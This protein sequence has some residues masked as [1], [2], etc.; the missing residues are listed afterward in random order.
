MART[1]T[2][3]LGNEKSRLANIVLAYSETE[4]SFIA[5]GGVNASGQSNAQVNLSYTA[6]GGIL[7]S[8]DSTDSEGNRQIASGGVVVSGESDINLILSF[9]GSGIITASG[10][11]AWIVNPVVRVATGGV[12]LSGS[13]L[14]VFE[15]RSC[16]L[17]ISGVNGPGEA[18]P[19]GVPV[20]EEFRVF[21][22]C[23]SQSSVGGSSVK[24]FVECIEMRYINS[25]FLSARTFCNQGLFVLNDPVGRQIR[26]LE[27]KSEDATPLSFFGSRRHYKPVAPIEEKIIEQEV[28]DSIVIEDPILKNIKNTKKRASKNNN[29]LNQNK[30]EKE[31]ICFDSIIEKSLEILGVNYSYVGFSK[32][33]DNSENLVIE[34]VILNEPISK[35]ISNSKKRARR[36]NTLLETNK[37]NKPIEIENELDFYESNDNLSSLALV[38]KE[39]QK[40]KSPK[41][42]VESP[43]PILNHGKSIKKN[44]HRRSSAPRRHPKLHANKKEIE[45]LQEMRENALR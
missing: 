23:Y 26:L 5:S 25:A 24:Q 9:S 18:E 4:K 11:A 2:G 8:G 6:S 14:C 27:A 32:K 21:V 41:I 17:T 33:K 42:K 13:A 34:A 43:Q 12:E 7:I 19:A 45:K 38:A 1:F 31:E 3:R 37:I 29:I 39:K 40:V 44:V 30:V 15:E 36:M 35:T 22:D 28:L 16:T 10:R 20:E